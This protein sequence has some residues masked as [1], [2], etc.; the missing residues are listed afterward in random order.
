[1]REIA[2]LTFM[3]AL[4]AIAAFCACAQTF[5]TL[6]R[7]DGTDGQF[8][9]AALVEGTDGNLYGTALAGGAYGSGTV[10]RI[11]PDGK[12]T[13]LYNFCAQSGCPDG[14]YV[15]G[16]VLAMS[17]NFYSTAANGGAYGMG[18]VFRITPSG[19][20]T[21]LYSFCAQG[22]TV[23]PDGVGSGGLVQ[24]A[25]GDFYGTTTVGGSSNNGCEELSGCGTIYRIT[26]SGV[27]TTLY[28][29]CEQPGTSGCPG[30]GYFGGPLV[31][32]INGE[33]YQVTP[34]GG[35]D[36]G[37]SIVQ[38]TPQGEVTTLVDLCEA[39]GCPDGYNP[40][41]GL[42][43]AADGNFYGTAFNGGVYDNGTVFKVTQGG[44]LSLLYSFCEQTGCPDGAASMAGLVEG[45]DGNFYGTTVSGGDQASGT[46]FKV[47]PSGALTTLYSFPPAGV[48]GPS[49]VA[50]LIQATNGDFYGTTSVGGLSCG[51]H[52]GCGTIFRVSLGLAP[53]VKTLPHS[54]KIGDAISI[55]GTDLTGT[56]AVTFN[57]APATFTVLSGSHLTATIPAGAITGK[58]QVTTPGGVLSSAGPFFVR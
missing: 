48:G 14:T 20:L 31:Q 18:T 1:M 50:P 27:L 46:V 37:N 32:A 7:F 51:L 42:I 33:F 12:L 54:G 17:G 56:T 28:R 29:F 24:A 22:G 3:P 35:A 47:T 39:S 19:E 21:T 10:F 49:P 26:P 6:H 52:V 9:V 53:F 45:S 34:W 40:M 23:C 36:G 43:Q 8:P 30:Y 2:H 11:T 38:V 25:S 44:T 4:L 41:G 15:G 5:T 55:L 13:T 58:I 16:L 57:G